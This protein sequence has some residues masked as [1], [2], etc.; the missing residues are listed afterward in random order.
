MSDE[1]PRMGAGD[2][3]IHLLDADGQPERL[4]LKPSYNAAHA[5]SA[6]SGG[7][8]KV[9]QRI[10]DGD[11]AAVVATISLGLGYGSGNRAPADLPERVWRTGLTDESGGLSERCI[12]YLRVLMGGGR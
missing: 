5:L 12:T 11:V 2:V 9:M 6:Q 3:E 8:F 1:K 7:I 4:V 10:V